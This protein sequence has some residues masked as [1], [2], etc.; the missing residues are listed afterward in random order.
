MN[1]NAN[2]FDQD[3]YD[4]DLKKSRECIAAALRFAR[5]GW[6]N[7]A[8]RVAQEDPLMNS[9]ATK[10]AWIAWAKKMIEKE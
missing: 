7:N 6:W 2:R 3:A 8:W 1:R 9:D 5:A 10:K 4:R